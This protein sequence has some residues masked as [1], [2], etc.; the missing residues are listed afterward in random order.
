MLEALE[1][2]FELLN[3][4]MPENKEE[5]DS[6]FDVSGIRGEFPQFFLRKGSET[7]A[8]FLGQFDDI[9]KINERSNWPKSI[10]KED[11]TT[12]DSLFGTTNTYNGKGISVG[13]GDDASDG[14]GGGG[15]I[16]GELDDDEDGGGGNIYAG[17]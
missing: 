12:W 13:D 17:L 9:E 6:Y 16:Y 15:G 4:A 3:C 8:T 2:P 5:R 10:L 11:E 7:P 1:I 14:S